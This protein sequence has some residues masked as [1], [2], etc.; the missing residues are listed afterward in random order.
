MSVRSAGTSE[1][2]RRRVAKVIL[3]WAD[4][5]LVMEHKYAA[6]IG[7]MFPGESI[8]PLRSLDIPDDYEFMAPELV[9]LPTSAVEHELSEAGARIPQ[10]IP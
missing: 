3:A 2:S 5:V 10:S 8:P 7:A 1:S 9:E 4:V 6:R